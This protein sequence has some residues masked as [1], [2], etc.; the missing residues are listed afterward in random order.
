[1]AG[2]GVGRCEA[3]LGIARPSELYECW[4]NPLISAAFVVNL[5]ICRLIVGRIEVGVASSSEAEGR[6]L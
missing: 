5:G 1:M 3:K 2:S 6:E 4:S